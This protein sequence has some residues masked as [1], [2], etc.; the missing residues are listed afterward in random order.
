MQ[1]HVLAAD[2]NM[3]FLYPFR[4]EFRMSYENDKVCFLYDMPWNFSQ[5]WARL[6][7]WCCM[8]KAI[9]I[10]HTTCFSVFAI[11]VVWFW[12]Q[13]EKY[14]IALYFLLHSGGQNRKCR[15][16]CTLFRIHTTSH[17]SMG[18]RKARMIH[19]RKRVTWMPPLC[20]V[21]KSVFAK[22]L[23][24]NLSGDLTGNLSRRTVPMPRI[25]GRPQLL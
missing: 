19:T 18:S 21:I 9:C 15:M 7:L 1:C 6:E 25:R 16:K 17:L 11:Y 24:R 8:K 10:I 2:M 23:S 4:P 13:W 3:S 20:T 12:K 5:F 22:D 14:D